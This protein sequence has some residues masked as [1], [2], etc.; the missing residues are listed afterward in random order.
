MSSSV[1]VSPEATDGDLPVTVS[2]TP[3]GRSGPRPRDSG[4]GAGRAQHGREL[5]E[6]LG[7]GWARLR[8]DADE[9]HMLCRFADPRAP[10][11]WEA[12]PERQWWL[13][14]A[15]GLAEVTRTDGGQVSRAGSTSRWTVRS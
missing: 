1:S 8:G 5:P 13:R 12:T 3:P 4:L 9:W 15:Q 11:A 7:G 2:Y 10:A 6:V 14:S